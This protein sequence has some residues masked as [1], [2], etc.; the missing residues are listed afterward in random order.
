MVSVGG[1]GELAIVAQMPLTTPPAQ[2]DVIAL[3]L[4]DGKIMFKVIER[5]W[6]FSQNPDGGGAIAKV[7]VILTQIGT[8]PNST[9]IEQKD[10]EN[11]P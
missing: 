6:E 7:V 8:E 9:A 4:S 11:T 3:Q 5:R 2:G 10:P 1:S